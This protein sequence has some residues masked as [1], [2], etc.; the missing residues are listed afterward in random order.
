[1]FFFKSRDPFSIH[2]IGRDFLGNW[3]KKHDIFAS[4]AD[5]TNWQEKNPD[6]FPR[7]KQRCYILY[8]WVVLFQSSYQCRLLGDDDIYSNDVFLVCLLL[9]WL[10]STVC[11][12][13][14]KFSFVILSNAWKINKLTIQIVKNQKKNSWIPRVVAQQRFVFQVQHLLPWWDWRDQQ[15][16]ERKKIL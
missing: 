14:Y 9:N 1:M 6:L 10:L 7:V 16:L 11:Q 12:F 4:W 13:K 15:H 5:R 8:R 2:Q 3:R